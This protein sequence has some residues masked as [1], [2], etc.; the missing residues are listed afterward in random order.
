MT[1]DTRA[2]YAVA[3]AKRGEFDLATT[4]VIDLVAED[5]HNADAHRAWGRLLLEQGKAIDAVAA[6]RVAASLDPLRALSHFELANALL[7]EGQQNLYFPLIHW[8]E[9]QEAVKTGLGLAPGDHRGLELQ[10]KIEEHRLNAT[11]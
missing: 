11:G 2:E 3:A 6:F 10:S 8:V 1:T 5:W 9:A 4:V 7:V